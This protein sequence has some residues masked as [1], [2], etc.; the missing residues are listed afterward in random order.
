MKYFSIFLITSFLGFS[1]NT[2]AQKFDWLEIAGGTGNKTVK[3]MAHH[4]SS[5]YVIGEFTNTFSIGGTIISNSH[6]YLGYIAKFDT[7]GNFHWIKTIDAGIVRVKSIDTDPQGNLYVAGTNTSDIIIGNDTLRDGVGHNGFVFK[8]DQNGSLKWLK[9][10][11][12]RY[13]LNLD[14]L[15]FKHEHL[16]LFGSFNDS[17]YYDSNFVDAADMDCFLLKLDSGGQLIWH[18][19]F[20]YDNNSWRYRN[21]S[22][23]SDIYV[24]NISDIY[25]TGNYYDTLKIDNSTVHTNSRTDNELFL[26]KLDSTGNLVWLES[27]TSSGNTLERVRIKGDSIGNIYIVGNYSGVFQIDTV[28][29]PYSSSLN[30][31]IFTFKISSIGNAIYGKSYH[32]GNQPIINDLDIGK[33]GSLYTTGTFGNYLIIAGDTIL[34]SGGEEVFLMKHDSSG[35]FQWFQYAGGTSADEGKSIIVD[36]N[37]NVYLGGTYTGLA[38]FGTRYE[39]SVSNFRSDIFL[40]RLSE[41]GNYTAKIQAIGDTIWCGN[42]S[43]PVQLMTPTTGTGYLFQWYKGNIPLAGETYRNLFP[44]D[45]GSYSVIV[46]N[47]GCIDTSRAITITADSFPQVSLSPFANVCANDTAFA[48]SGGSPLGGTWSGNGVNNGYFDP[49]VADTGWVKIN[50]IY[51]NGNCSDTASQNIY[52]SAVPNANI[53]GP[54]SVCAFSTG[55]T[56]TAN[57]GQNLNYQWNVSGGSITNGQGTSSISVDWGAAGTGIVTLTAFRFNSVSPCDTIIVHDTISIDNPH[58]NASIQGTDSVCT[59][60]N[61]TY[62]VPSNGILYQWQ[63]TGGQIVSGLNTSSINV[64]WNTAGQGTLYLRM[65]NSCFNDT[66]LRDTVHIFP[67]V[68]PT[69]TGNASVC[70]GSTEIYSAGTS[71]STYQWSVTGGAIASGQG[72]SSISVDWGNASAGNISLTETIS[73]GCSGTDNLQVA[74]NSVNT[75]IIQSRDT[76]FAQENSA[77]YQW[78]QCNLSTSGF[79]AIPGET[80]SFFIAANSGN[81]ALEVT[82]NGCT[83]TSACMQVIITGINENPIVFE[84]LNIYPNPSDGLF[85]LE[86]S[87]ERQNNIQI[88]L[89]DMSGKQLY[90]K[91]FYSTSSIIEKLDFSHLTKGIY[92]LK[93]NSDGEQ[94]VEKLVIQ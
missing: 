20:G 63:V 24:D 81:Y 77:I 68:L 12:S 87:N 58:F 33:N 54:A 15:T 89:L 22:Y 6:R 3:D 43:N 13:G 51:S 67:G 91:D 50:Y 29:L 16:Y 9:S 18:K 55:N 49:S 65:F 23:A 14:A 71:N 40:T 32:G 44:Q 56:Y 92:F 79:T 26:A 42:L 46:N 31:S 28:I 62:S 45:S 2:Q 7:L 1:L 59:N 82:K 57:S 27:S 66:I 48:L 19:K 41:C 78:L 69:I 5:L 72:A 70:S 74:I 60:V 83:D 86:I 93:L 85:T 11:N 38:L 21:S 90:H 84:G 4:N 39:T 88:E 8:M 25:L 61:Y 53:S 34:S 37:D 75:A 10:M 17:L 73:N 64:K 30:S 52:V 94:K 76:L 35:Q 36:K 47:N 80:S